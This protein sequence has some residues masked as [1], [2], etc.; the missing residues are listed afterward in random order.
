MLSSIFQHVRMLDGRDRG[1]VIEVNREIAVDLIERKQALPIPDITAK[2]A[3]DPWTEEELAAHRYLDN[4]AS[5]EVSRATADKDE[6]PVVAASVGA[7]SS[8]VS[9]PRD[10]RKK[11]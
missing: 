9:T 6:V 5:P 4:G 8:E 7:V 2:G 1:Q 10:R 11:R 3:L